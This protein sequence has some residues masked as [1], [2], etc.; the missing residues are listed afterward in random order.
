MNHI[1]VVCDGEQDYA[2]KLVDYL[3]LKEGFPF[4]VRCFSEPEKLKAFASK[5]MVEVVLCSEE[6]SRT[7]EKL[8]TME[9]ME[10]V[11]L[12][13]LKE[14]ETFD[15]DIQD[16]IWK[17]QSC[18]KLIKE[19]MEIL[20]GCNMDYA[21]TSRRKPMKLIGLYSPIKR[22]LQTTLGL[23][24]GQYLGKRGK[25]LYISLEC[26]ST[27]PEILKLHFQKDLSDVL[28]DLHGSSKSARL[29]LGSIV[30]DFG[31]LDILPPMNNQNDL[32]SIT[33]REWIDFLK[34]LERETDYEYVILDFSDGVQGIGSILRQCDII[35][36][37]K[38]GDGNAS[39]K[40]EKY[41]RQLEKGGY[42]DLVNRIQNVEVGDYPNLPEAIN[43]MKTTPFGDLVK[44]LL[45]DEIYAME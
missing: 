22:C 11:K 40:I 28:Y 42:G 19:L 18:E 39:R 10:S 33:S 2:S 26:C 21:C 3:N 6:H 1:L 25:A 32:L 37:V 15:S 35:Y 9:N 24:L 5:Q 17:Y 30:L 4:D 27:V 7:V 45:R 31:G 16:K 13:V 8:Q 34:R 38:N 12:I 36:Q 23:L 44:N 29:Y 14:S 41:Q 20:S 43:R